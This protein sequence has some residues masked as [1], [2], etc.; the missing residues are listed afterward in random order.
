[1][2]QVQDHVFLYIKAI[3]RKKEG[4]LVGYMTSQKVST[5]VW[6]HDILMANFGQL[7][8]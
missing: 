2:P 5:L 3:P 7:Y 8:N 6:V 1:M 4:I